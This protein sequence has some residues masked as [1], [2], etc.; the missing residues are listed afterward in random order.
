MSARWA[1][2]SLLFVILAGCTDQK[3]PRITTTIPLSASPTLP[4]TPTRVTSN[5]PILASTKTP[6]LPTLTSSPPATP[7]VTPQPEVNIE[8]VGQI[9]GESNALA[10]QGQYI[11]LGVGPR[12][13]VLDISNPRAPRALGQSEVLPGVVSRVVLINSRAYLTTAQVGDGRGYLLVLSLADP[14]KPQLIGSLDLQS[15]ALGLAVNKGYAYVAS[16][17]AGL[18][19]IDVSDPE[20][21]RQVGLAE[22]GQKV[23]AVA[24]AGHYVYVTEDKSSETSLSGALQVIDVVNPATPQVI[25]SLE[26]TYYAQAITIID[27]YAYLASGGLSV[28]DIS[29]RA[30]PRQVGFYQEGPF[31]DDV[32]VVGGYAF[33]STNQYCDVVGICPRQV[34]MVDVTDPAQP[35]GRGYRTKGTHWTGLGAGRG[36]VGRDGLLYVATESG[37]SVLDVTTWKQIGEYRSVGLVGDVAVSK[38]YAYVAD[39]YGN[40]N[41]VE[42]HNPAG[43]TRLSSLSDLGLPVD[44]IAVA[45]GYAFLG[46]WDSGL[47]VVDVRNARRPNL[48]AQLELGGGNMR[49]AA[50]GEYVYLVSDLTV[51]DDTSRPQLRVLDVKSPTQ[52]RIIGSLMLTGSGYSKIMIEDGYAYIGSQG[53]LEVVNVTDPTTLRKVGEFA[54]SPVESEYWWSMT[55]GGQ[56]AYFIRRAKVEPYPVEFLV[57]DLT[58]PSLPKQST[59]LP[60]SR[61]G[62]D[63]TMAGN[64]AYV[65][66][67]DGVSVIDVSN[68]TQPR[69]VGVFEFGGSKIV[70]DGDYLYVAGGD[71][72]LLIL[73]AIPVAPNGS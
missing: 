52:P 31:H 64:Y 56:Y 11:Y 35:K 17:A 26:L 36:L 48:V 5:A 39:G 63:V 33:I 24:V 51:F 29:D 7:T 41:I 60:L 15:P 54:V 13:V 67:T 19:I 28:I 21:L 62:N 1:L 57:I 10:L 30:N 4:P 49:L 46:I 66:G 12:L 3:P 50:T 45:N 22:T 8:L 2:I 71:S 32:A 42:V 43:L 58:D 59:I 73:R 27:D 47:T 16:G 44:R 37:L 25:G 18:R 53:R 65:L 14:S 70:A 6:E 69:E 9:G 23:T 55:V 72:G 20:A 34:G 40:L 61:G 68:P 38:D